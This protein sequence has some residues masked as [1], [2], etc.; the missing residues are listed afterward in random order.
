MVNNFVAINSGRSKV[1]LVKRKRDTI[2]LSKPIPVKLSPDI[3]ARVDLLAKRVGEAR[4]TIMRLAMGIGLDAL[5]K[6]FH[7]TSAPA[8]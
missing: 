6:L 8:A 5:E 1:N 4:S 2:P 7:S 3:L